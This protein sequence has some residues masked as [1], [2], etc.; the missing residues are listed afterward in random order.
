MSPGTRY[1][2]LT[3][4]RRTTRMWWDVAVWSGCNILSFFLLVKQTTSNWSPSS[5]H[6]LMWRLCAAPVCQFIQNP[7]VVEPKDA[8]FYT[9]WCWHII[10]A[11]Q[12]W[13][14]PGSEPGI[15]AVFPAKMG[16]QTGWQTGWQRLYQELWYF[17]P[18]VTCQ[19]HYHFPHNCLVWWHRFVGL[20]VR[21]FS[22][23]WWVKDLFICQTVNTI[24]PTDP[25]SEPLAFSFTQTPSVLC[26]GS[27]TTS[28]GGSE[29]QQHFPPLSAF[30]TFHTDGQAEYQH[31][32]PAL[33]GAVWM[34]PL[35]RNKSVLK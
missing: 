14:R 28:G 20:S 16:W 6:S 2:G 4:G 5:K 31:T 12:L 13:E 8:W 33:K 9:S 10:T 26:C 21:H 25:W 7:S 1:T 34:G 11:I 35:W 24:R 29:Q 27:N 32:I 17:F 30:V 22:L 3:C 23:I 19:R 18:H 15:D